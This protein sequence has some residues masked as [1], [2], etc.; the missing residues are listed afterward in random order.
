MKSLSARRIV[1]NNEPVDN[2][3]GPDELEEQRLVLVS[4]SLVKPKSLKFNID[5]LLG[6]PCG[7]LFSV[8]VE[9]QIGF[10]AWKRAPTRTSIVS[11]GRLQRLGVVRF[12]T[13]RPDQ[14]CLIEYGLFYIST[15]HRTLCFGRAR[16]EK[17][18]GG[19]EVYTYTN[20]YAFWF[21]SF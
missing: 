4:S 6:A 9:P 15:L 13:R 20:S 17:G 1:M 14:D 11:S 12:P 18:M 3:D 5:R 10:T 19:K 16:Q 2:L 7:E 21:R 8:G